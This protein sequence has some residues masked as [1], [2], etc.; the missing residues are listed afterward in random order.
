MAEETHHHARRN[1]RKKAQP[2]PFTPTTSAADARQ[3]TPVTT[4]LVERP[5]DSTYTRNPWGVTASPGTTS[6]A[7][8]QQ[9]QAPRQAAPT[10]RGRGWE[11]RET[12]RADQKQRTIEVAQKLSSN[13]RFEDAPGRIQ[14]LQTERT[15]ALEEGGAQAHGI[16]TSVVT[17]NGA[18][19]GTG[20]NRTVGNE[21]GQIVDL[22]TLR[23]L[24]ERFGFD[25]AAHQRAFGCAEVYAVANAIAAKKLKDFPP[26]A[27][28]GWKITTRGPGG[29]HKDACPDC[30]VM[31]AKLGIGIER[32]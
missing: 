32:A 6:L 17:L 31:L 9:E 28:R 25:P 29:M 8:I 4:S 2:A 19:I 30:A 5:G 23:S 18:P 14:H 22:G 3:S 15:H 13:V 16:T 10:P 26:D 11:L 27:F 1:R 12:T 20:K 7:Q 24:G 21:Q